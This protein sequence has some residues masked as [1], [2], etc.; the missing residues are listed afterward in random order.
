LKASL[1]A[2]GSELLRPGFR[3]S[4]S[5]WI[6]PRLES[7]GWEVVS[8]RIVP[9]DVAAIAG[10]VREARKESRLVLITG[11][12][13]PTR[14][15]RTREALAA[16]LARPLRLDRASEQGI[17]R[18]CR[19]YGFPFRSP[20]RRQALLPEGARSVPNPVGSAPGIWFADP[21]GILLVLPGVPGEMRRMLSTLLPRIGR[22][23]GVRIETATLRIAGLGESRVDRR[24]AHAVRAFPEVEVSTLASPGEVVVQLRARARNAR[25]EVAKFRHWMVQRFKEDL[26]SDSGESLEGVVIRMLRRRRLRLAAAESC[27]AGLVGARLTR[28]PG[29]S[30]AFLAG[31]VCYND[32]AKEKLLRVPRDTLNAAGAV[33]R[34]TAIA[35]ARGAAFLFDAPVTVAVTGIAGPGGAT[36]G[37]PV[38]TV[39]WAVVGPGRSLITRKRVLAGDREKIRH[40]AVAVALDLVRRSLLRSQSAFPSRRS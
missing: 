3:E 33:S 22:M 18:W 7:A 21:Q 17:R 6:T 12:I 19:R 14:D 23:S 10:A 34:S 29:A 28:V 8:R 36:R 16:V 37:K 24:L 1:V 32:A 26:V 31:A 4:H 40:H 30:R 5:D 15:D 11:G 20:Q 38:G 13:G 9:D 35:M 2:V 27:T 25:A 39:H